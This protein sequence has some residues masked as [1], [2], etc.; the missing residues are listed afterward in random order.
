MEAV[1]GDAGD[2]SIKGLMI[3]GVFVL[4]RTSATTVRFFQPSS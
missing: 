1:A 4:Q 2:T 3:L